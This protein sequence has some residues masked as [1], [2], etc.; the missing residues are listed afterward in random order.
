VDLHIS[1]DISI[2]DTLKLRA[3]VLIPVLKAARAELGEERANHLILEALRASSRERFR[4]SRDGLEGSPKEKWDTL[5]ASSLARIREDDLEM[6]LLQQTPRA[7]DYNIRRC[8][9]AELF[10]WIGEP[11]LGLVLVCETDF[12][13]A[14]E[15]GSPEVVLTRTQT[16][17]E[18]AS[19]CDFRYR[20]ICQHPA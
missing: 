10:H 18:G 4:R 17:M 9:F 12:Q 14:E 1:P 11:E 19:H 5:M 16:L 20:F 2:L 3:Q 6:E 15:V 13:A 8:Q 7:W